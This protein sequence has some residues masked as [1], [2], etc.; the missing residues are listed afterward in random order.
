[1]NW[2]PLSGRLLVWE[3][4]PAEVRGGVIVPDATDTSLDRDLPRQVYILA[5]TDCPAQ[6][7]IGQQVV[8]GPFAGTQLWLDFPTGERK[9]KYYVIH[10]EDILVIEEE[11]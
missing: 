7:K 3:P 10:W 1:M 9:G 6:L 8:I 4:P 5:L 11:A 2:R